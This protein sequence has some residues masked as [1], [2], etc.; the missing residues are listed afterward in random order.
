MQIAL[1]SM[2]DAPLE[3]P[4]P[5]PGILLGRGWHMEKGQ[6]WSSTMRAPLIVASSAFPQPQPLQIRLQVFNAAPDRPRQLCIKSQG[7]DPVTITIN[8]PMPVSL[9]L[10]TPHHRTGATWSPIWLELDHLDSPFLIGASAD[11]RLLGLSI[12]DL[13]PNL[14][15]LAFPLVFGKSEPT[16][17]VVAEGWAAPEDGG[18]WSLGPRASLLLPGYLFS[19]ATHTLIAEANILHRGADEAPLEVDVTQAGVVLTTWRFSP[20]TSHARRCPLPV[21]AN[22]LDRRI[23]LVIRNARSPASLGINADPRPLGLFLKRISLL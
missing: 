22:S 19:G 16:K 6:A 8:S 12:K 14:P 18:V 15:R 5:C 1:E 20:E 7:H 13:V 2:F 11:E 10:H 23:D 4:A 21:Q 9:M 3:R 17:Y